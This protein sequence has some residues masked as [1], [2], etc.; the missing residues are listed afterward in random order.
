M[1]IKNFKKLA[2]TPERKKVLEIVDAGI[3]A[4]KPEIAIKENV[5]LKKEILLIKNKKFDLSKI[6]HVYVLGIGKAAYETGKALEKI[7]KDK[8]TDGILIDINKGKLKYLKSYKGDHPLP[9]KENTEISKKIVDLAK[10]AKEDDLVICLISGGAS[11]LF[12]L[13]NEISLGTLKKLTQLLLKSGADIYEVNTVRKHV[14]QVKGGGLAKFCY[15]A[16]VVSL[17]F[18]DVPGDDLSFIASGP[19]VKD[20]TTKKEA[21]RILKKYDI[22]NGF[23]LIE[24]PK[25]DKYFKNVSNLLLLSGRI[26]V[27]AMEKKCKDLKIPCSVYSYALRGEAKIVGRKI[28]QRMPKKGALIASGETTVKVEGEGKGG[29]NQEL[30]L[31]ALPYLEKTVFVSVA[32]DGLDNTEAAGAIADE[33]SLKKAYNKGLVWRE[34]IDDNDSFNYFKEIGDLVMTGPTGTNVAD[35]IVIYK[36]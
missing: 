23:D 34:Y 11:A 15:P 22:E 29:R 6:N 10:K 4:V 27:Q 9:S 28:L 17:I 7:L 25:Q 13:P 24:T 5:S 8:I 14:S 2:K 1:N 31:G 20:K 16:Q 26:A 32:S 19:T 35:L 12:S 36:K 30:V 33:N 21:E 3:E 18:S